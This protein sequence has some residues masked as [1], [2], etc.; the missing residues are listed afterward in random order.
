MREAVTAK[1]CAC[2]GSAETEPS[3]EQTANLDGT[4]VGLHPLPV[5]ATLDCTVPERRDGL[6]GVVEIICAERT[7]RQA[8]AGEFPRESSSRS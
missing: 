8:V 6:A 3:T 4:P 5:V 2:S 1:R 7:G